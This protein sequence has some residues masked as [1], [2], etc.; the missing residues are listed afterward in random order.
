MQSVSD[1]VCVVREDRIYYDR[2]SI[3]DLIEKTG[4]TEGI[5]VIH[6]EGQF[7]VSRQIHDLADKYL[8]GYEGNKAETGFETTAEVVAVV[9]E[10]KG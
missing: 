7:I 2:E 1:I 8:P 6:L 10:Q 9:I 4:A 3:L 5:F